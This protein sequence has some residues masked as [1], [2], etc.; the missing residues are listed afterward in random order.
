M[1][2]LV[3]I[4]A[5]MTLAGGLFMIGGTN[6]SANSSPDMQDNPITQ[7]LSRNK[8][9]GALIVDVRTTEEWEAGHVAGAAHFSLEERMFQNQIPNVPKDTEMYLYCR[10]GNRTAQAKQILDQAGFTNV[11]DLGAMTD[12]QVAGASIVT[13]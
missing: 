2:K 13:N 8:D 6:S 11:T 1:K 4:G 7:A 3:I 5:I 9:A 12:W 10:S